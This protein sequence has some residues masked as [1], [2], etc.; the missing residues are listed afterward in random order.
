MSINFK[1]P[2][3]GLIIKF[4]KKV[5]AT[6][7]II[8]ELRKFFAKKF[9]IKTNKFGEYSAEKWFEF[10][11]EGL[12]YIIELNKQGISFKE[13]YTSMVLSKIFTFNDPGYVDLMSP[14]GIGIAGVVYNYDGSV[15]ASD[16][17][18]ML[19]EM[20]DETFKL[21]NLLNDSYEDLF[22]SDALLDPLEESF[23]FSAPMCNDCAFE[24]YCG[25]EPVY[26]HAVAIVQQHSYL[27]A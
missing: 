14:A 5:N 3:L 16:E 15:F 21:G 2:P 26:H 6:N 24:S 10:Y 19:A 4:S 17:S 27:L 13:F 1:N 12:D 9:A 7:I 25:A 18:R 23:A 11:K 8:D 20:G 22:L